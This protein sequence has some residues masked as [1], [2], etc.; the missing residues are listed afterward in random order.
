MPIEDHPLYPKWKA[1]LELLLAARTTRD[2]HPIGS[3]EYNAA[4]DDY[5]RALVAYD[6][7]GRIV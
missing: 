4:H 7:V 1:A 6:E 2:N 5:E 3:K